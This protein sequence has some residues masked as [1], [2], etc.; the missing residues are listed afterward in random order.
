MTI[1]FACAIS[2]APGIVAWRDAAPEAQAQRLYAGLEHLRQRLVESRLE[3]LILFTAEHWTNFFLDHMSPFC[4]GRA[5]SYTGP[6][7]P[8]LKLPKVEIPGDPELAAAL[9]DHCYA[10]AIEPAF[11]YE[12]ALDHGTIIPL[13]FVTPA[14]DLPI[15]PIMI[16]SLAA[17]QPSVRRCYEL[18]QRIGEV[19]RSAERRIGI[20][21]TGG[22]SHDPG[23]RRHGTIDEPFDRRFLAA[24]A[25]GD[26]ARLTGYT[27]GD[28]AAAGAG[29]LELLCW[30]AMA[31]ALGR[32]QGEVIAYEAVKPWA[33]GLGLV[34][35]SGFE[36]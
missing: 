28:L 17:P 8:W 13:H 5:A 12:M 35:F 33:T 1:A 36:P 11:A 22:M 32:F 9:L 25:D 16:N 30:I 19:A 6:V 7:E 15:V 14:M 29:A 34:S 26:I 18:G 27:V 10:H 20:I 2:H 24:M 31:G 3:A 23:E 4:V 21:A